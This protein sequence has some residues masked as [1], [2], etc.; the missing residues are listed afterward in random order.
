MAAALLPECYEQ[1]SS[2]TPLVPCVPTCAKPRPLA[3]HA[4]ASVRI[5][6]PGSQLHEQSLQVT[7]W[8]GARGQMGGSD[9]T[10]S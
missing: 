4:E 5:S 1:L 9:H 6:P 8:G 2:G 7:G 10:F 3:F